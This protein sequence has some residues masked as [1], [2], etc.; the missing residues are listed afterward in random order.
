MRVHK[1]WIAGCEIQG[2]QSGDLLIVGNLQSRLVMVK[3]RSSHWS[4]NIFV[5]TVM[6]LMLVADMVNSHSPSPLGV[7]PLSASNVIL[8]I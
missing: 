6:C 1:T 3:M 5:L 7:T 8:A 2:S 4:S